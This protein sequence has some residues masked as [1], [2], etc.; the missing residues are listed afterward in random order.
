MTKFHLILFVFL[1]LSFVLSCTTA[2]NEFKKYSGKYKGLILTGEG[3]SY[4]NIDLEIDSGKAKVKFLD[5]N[6]V[7][8]IDSGVIIF[9]DS[10]AEIKFKKEI[11]KLKEDN[12]KMVLYFGDDI[13]FRAVLLHLTN[14]NKDQKGFFTMENQI[15]SKYFQECEK[16]YFRNFLFYNKDDIIIDNEAKINQ[17]YNSSEPVKIIIRTLDGY[18]S[19][20]EGMSSF[21]ARDDKEMK[22]L[23]AK[24][25][26]K[27][28]DSTIISQNMYEEYE[29]NFKG[30]LNAIENHFPIFE[31]VTRYVEGHVKGNKWDDN[32]V[33]PKDDYIYEAGNYDHILYSY[34]HSLLVYNCG[35]LKRY[36]IE[37]FSALKDST[38]IPGQIYD[39]VNY[40]FEFQER[41]L[42]KYISE[43]YSV[44]SFNKE[45]IKN[46]NKFS[47]EYNK[48][49]FLI[50]LS[51]PVIEGECV[52][53]RWIVEGQSEKSWRT[54][55]RK[56]F[57]ETFYANT[58]LPKSFLQEARRPVLE[59]DY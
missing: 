28:A 22:S 40:K 51:N 59:E 15:I 34:I 26:T 20:R 53:G 23:V 43:R 33:R 32:G 6:G 24:A 42:M 9:S 4:R 21:N 58:F 29:L 27:L 18:G 14:K 17:I 37:S 36:D 12:E 44:F 10:T 47:D 38:R 57:F 3:F 11:G 19:N 31:V 5:N 56:S 30:V 13:K 8:I 55:V 41:E 46:V 48:K 54:F 52:N 7:Q 35:Y 2:N 25:K 50:S 39:S 1:Q 45:K 16:N 49:S